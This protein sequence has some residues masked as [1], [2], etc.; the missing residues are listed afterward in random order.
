MFKRIFLS[1]A[2]IA[3]I[4]SLV[5]QFQNCAEGSFDVA[6]MSIPV[7]EGDGDFKKKDVHVPIIKDKPISQFTP[8]L[9]DR[10][11][12]AAI[13]ENAFGP[14]WTREPANVQVRAQDFGKPCSIYEEY[15]TQINGR[16]VLGTGSEVCRLSSANYNVSL[17]TLATTARSSYLLT[18][19]SYLAHSDTT[20]NYFMSKVGSESE[21]NTY[22]DQ[23]LTNAYE[24]FFVGKPKPSVTIID[25]LRF[26]GVGQSDSKKAWSA[27]AF[28]LCS[29][30]QWQVL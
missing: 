7:P 1:L 12:V 29:S 9:M 27:I 30:G 5:T 8:P 15:L 21:R 10:Q 11:S 6:S 17:E 16:A 22:S 26:L 19:C 23:V 2:L 25:A 28:T 18:A 14:S 3:G 20:L 4:G 24:L 13:L